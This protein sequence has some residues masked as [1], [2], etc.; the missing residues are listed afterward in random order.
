MTNIIRIT[1]IAYARNIKNTVFPYTVNNHLIQFWHTM[2]QISLNKLIK[3]VMFV[4]QY[5]QICA[6][7]CALFCTTKWSRHKHKQQAINKMGMADVRYI[8]NEREAALRAKYRNYNSSPVRQTSHRLPILLLFVYD[9]CADCTMW[10]CLHFAVFN[11]RIS[12]FILLFF[13]QI[14]QDIHA[15]MQ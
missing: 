14:F 11:F 10:I 5:T 12:L 4:D 1:R 9:M 2:A 7:Y 13:P 3:Y 6:D 15:N 8:S